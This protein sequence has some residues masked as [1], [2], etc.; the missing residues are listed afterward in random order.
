MKKIIYIICL[1]FAS[2]LNAQQEAMFTHYMYNT[3]WQNPAYAGSRDA[4]TITGIHRSQWV[5][6]TGAPTGQTLTM[7]SPIADGKLGLGLSVRNDK[8]G[9]TKSTSVAADLAYILRLD[10]KSRLSFGIKGLVDFYN[11]NL[12]TLKLDQ[13]NDNNFSENISSTMPNVGTGVYYFRDRFYAGFSIPKLF[14]NKLG[15]SSNA[16]SV[17]QRH[18][19]FIIGGVLNLSNTVKLKPTCFVKA[20]KGA[21]IEADITGTFVFKNQFNAGIMYRTGDAVG[22]LLGYNFNEQFYLGYSFDWSILN[23]TGKYNSGSHEVIL[24]YDLIYPKLKGRIK[25]PRYF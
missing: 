2:N 4:L 21:P 17:E 25:S 10:E 15:S 6:F 24:R 8:I 13:T 11:N 5:N 22:I 18:Y 20:T 9:P 16:T 1:I 3:L 23:T 7:H 19:Y 14:A 12:N